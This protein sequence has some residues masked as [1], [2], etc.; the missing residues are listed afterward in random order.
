MKLRNFVLFL[1][2]RAILA[3]DNLGGCNV[4]EHH[5]QNGG[6]FI[7]GINGI[8]RDEEGNRVSDPNSDLP[9][10]TPFID[11]LWAPEI[12]YPYG[13]LEIC[14]GRFCSEECKTKGCP[15]LIYGHTC[16]QIRFCYAE[17]SGSDVWKMPDEVALANCDFSN[18]EQICTESEGA[19][20]D[21]CNF[22]VEEDAMLDLYLFA[23]KN[24]C[25]NSQKAAILVD[26]YD[27]VGDQCHSMG[28]GSSRVLTCTCNDADSLVD[29]CHSEFRQG[30]MANSPEDTACCAEGNCVALSKNIT[31]PDGMKAEA[32]RQE[33]CRDDLPGT[34]SVP[35]EDVDC[36][37]RTCS[38]CGLELHHAAS[39]TQC[40]SGNSTTNTGECGGYYSPFTCDFS[41]CAS[42]DA[43]HIGSDPYM[44]WIALADPQPVVEE[45]PGTVVDV[46]SGAGVF[47]TLL[48]AA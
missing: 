45:G 18:A 28:M 26:D 20:E 7:E 37:S 42:D 1:G 12:K 17:D 21:C 30:C 23:S 6:Y 32:N 35:G 9:G 43:W 11:S 19:D 15:D 13:S 24:G 48:A 39:W 14:T 47:N 2:T 22:Q 31:H 25:E 36:C 33:L 10:H 4:D 41:A 38:A 40:A 3:D 34:C 8:I 44:S 27:S 46:A 29:P 5:P 16:S